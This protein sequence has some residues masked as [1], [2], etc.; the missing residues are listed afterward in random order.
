[1]FE[2]FTQK[3]KSHNRLRKLFRIY[4][5]T[6]ELLNKI[7]YG[8]NSPKY[9]ERIWVNPKNISYKLELG[10]QMM[11]SGK[12]LT[13]RY[14]ER[15]SF[16]LVKNLDVFKICHRHFCE[17][18]SWAEAG[19]YEYMQ[20][21]INKHGEYDGCKN[22]CDVRAR[23]AKVDT[24]FENELENKRKSLPFGSTKDGFRE[25]DGI[26]VHIGSKG[27]ILFGG[28]GNHRLSIAK[29]LE[30]ECIPVQL[31]GVHID[32]LDILKNL[33]NNEQQ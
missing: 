5:L 2:A 4:R 32:Q 14:F 15:Q 22:I 30:I 27:E 26:L 7:K 25:E 19:A 8:K 6:G 17:D 10:P 33:R 20:E 21:L 3:V 12:V 23:Y 1:M 11:V 24:I 31:G 18:L 13:N 16:T 28:N 29:I 9:A